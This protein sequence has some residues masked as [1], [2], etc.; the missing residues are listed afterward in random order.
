MAISGC[1][2]KKP[3]IPL[4]LVSAV[5]GQ[6]TH[7]FLSEDVWVLRLCLSSAQTGPMPSLS[8][9]SWNVVEFLKSLFHFSAS[10]VLLSLPHYL[11]KK[12]LFS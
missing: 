10:H 1:L 12:Y 8:D 3:C 11:L 7:V 4:A 6:S 9:I 5:E 2:W